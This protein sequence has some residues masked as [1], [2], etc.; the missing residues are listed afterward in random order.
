MSAETELALRQER[1]LARSAALRA[2][3]AEQSAVLDVPF[4]FADRVH[5]GARWAWRERVV[6]VGGTVVVLLVL[7]PRRVWRLASFGLW[8]WRR[9]RRVQAWLAAAGIAP[10]A[11]RPASHGSNPAR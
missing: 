6:L 4:A 11:G 7:R 3:I 8:A 1:L 2:S 10:N 9:K 5:A